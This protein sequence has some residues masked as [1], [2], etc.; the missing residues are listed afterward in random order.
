MEIYDRKTALRVLQDISNK[1]YASLDIFG[2]PTH[3]I[4][5]CHF[6]EIRKKY[7]DDLAFK[8]SVMLSR[9]EYEQYKIFKK[10]ADGIRFFDML[11]Q[12]K[13]QVRKETAEKIFDSII[14]F[15]VKRIAETSGDSYYQISFDRLKELAKQFCVE[16][17]E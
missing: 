15:T 6:E 2:K 3:V 11:N 8:N 12:E 1:M 5:R 16:I 4:N 9:E 7:L 14:W 17:K 10:Q 13:E